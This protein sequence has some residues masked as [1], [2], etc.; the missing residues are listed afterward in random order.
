MST[1]SPPYT[2]HLAELLARLKR[3][4]WGYVLVD[5]VLFAILWLI[6]SFWVAFAIDFLPVT[7]GSTEMPQAGAGHCPGRDRLGP[8]VHRLSLDRTPFDVSH[9]RPTIGAA[10]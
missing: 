6:V 7:V 10:R 2:P 5:G 3:H 9:A 1:A 8:G 4:I